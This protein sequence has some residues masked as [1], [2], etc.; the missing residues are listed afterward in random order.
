M[1]TIRK[2]WIICSKRGNV[3][4]SNRNVFIVPEVASAGFFDNLFY[5]YL[6]AVF[7]V[8]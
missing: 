1:P 7:I 4:E 3:A 2:L 8:L 6:N 5:V